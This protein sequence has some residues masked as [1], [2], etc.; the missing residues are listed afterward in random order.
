MTGEEKLFVTVLIVNTLITLLY[1]LW[2]LLLKVP[3]EKKRARDKGQEEFLQDGRGTYV[4]RFVVMVLCPVIGPCFFLAGFLAYRLL[5]R[6]QVDLED[7]IFSKEKIKQRLKA[8]EER[9]RN[10]VP[11]EEAIRI[12][13]KK[14]KRA[15]LLNVI[16]GDIQE[17]LASIS[18]ALNNEDSEVAHYAASALMDEINEFR[19][20]VQRLYEQIGEEEEDETECEEMLLDYMDPILKQKIFSDLEQKKFVAIMEKTG[21]FLFEKNA[22]KLSAKRYE[23]LILCLIAQE[24]YEKAQLWCERLTLQYPQELAA[25][26]CRLKLYFASQNREQFFAVLEELKRSDVIVDS[27]TLE[28]IRVFE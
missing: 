1:L 9:E 25:Y 14:N 17:S 4:I 5:Y 11:L 27:E 21:E 3:A 19:L 24:E 10:V 6:E 26:T 18:L 2:G 8:D 16:K 28:L 20:Q 15:L 12:S 13:D 22:C 7:V 23:G